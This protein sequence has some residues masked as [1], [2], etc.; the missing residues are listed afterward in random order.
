MDTKINN[1]GPVIGSNGLPETIT[2]LE[3]RLQ[4]AW[5]C[6]SGPKGSFIYD[7][8]FGSR[9]HAE[10]GASAQRILALADEAML[11]RCGAKAVNCT[12]SGNAVQ[13]TLMT[14]FGRGTVL[15]KI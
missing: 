3:E 10:P 8:D 13:L 9:I 12:I 11:G 1:G 15:V 7:R 14:P 2:G 5:L 4:Q 6:L